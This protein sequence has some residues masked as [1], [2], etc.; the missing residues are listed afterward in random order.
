MT[1][2]TKSIKRKVLTEGKPIGKPDKTEGTGKKNKNGE[3]KTIPPYVEALDK[4]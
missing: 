1:A 4:F 2:T 3:E